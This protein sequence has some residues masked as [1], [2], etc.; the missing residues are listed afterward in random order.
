MV[1]LASKVSL[2]V[3]AEG[4]TPI[5]YQWYF[6]DKILTEATN[7]NYEISSMD[8]SQI[9]SYKVSVSNQFG[10]TISS[11]AE[12][13]VI[14]VPV[15][16][17]NGRSGLTHDLTNSAS[18]KIELKTTFPSANIFYTLDGSVPSVN[19]LIFFTNLVLTQSVSIQAV[20]FDTNL[21]RYATPPIPIRFWRPYDLN[22][23]SAGGGTVTITPEGGFTYNNLVHLKAVPAQGWE[24]AS[25][26]GDVISG[27]SEM[28]ITTEKRKVIS[29][30]FGTRISMLAVG[31]GTFE[32]KPN[33]TIYNYGTKI[34]MTAIPDKGNY[35]SSWSGSITGFAN[36]I[37]FTLTNANP[38]ITGNFSLLGTNQAALTTLAIGKGSVSLSIKTNLFTTSQ[39]V[40]LTAIPES[41]QRFL[42]WSGDIY[43]KQ[44]PL[45]VQMTESKMITANFSGGSL[46]YLDP[47]VS[48]NSQRFA[49]RIY[50]DTTK[51][52]VVQGSTNLRD[53]ED[54]VILGGISEKTEI[55]ES[56][57]GSPYRFFRV[58]SFP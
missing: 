32:R 52:Y 57:I 37:T 36:P 17:V 38:E 54:W 2:S 47:I 6:N 45:P 39:K 24:F 16:F 27:E 42:F 14:G 53:W 13:S 49:F 50:A 44:N 55:G 28:D 22:I 10:K 21:V 7:T 40:N 46:I 20:V 23:T 11:P 19:S 51:Y 33:Q 12:V 5:F 34:V 30:V 15:V 1:D 18:A 4:S 25:Y 43:S 41:G 26:T 29:A 9:G 31:N 58:L 48:T 8:F 3:T 35:F 56:L